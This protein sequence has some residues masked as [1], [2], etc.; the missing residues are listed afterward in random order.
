MGKTAAVLFG[1]CLY[2]SE[3]GRQVN[4]YDLLVAAIPGQSLRNMVADFTAGTGGKSTPHDEIGGR[5]SVLAS[6][7][8]LID[9]NITHHVWHVNPAYRSCMS[10]VGLA[11]IAMDIHTHETHVCQAYQFDTARKTL[12]LLDPTQFDY[13]LKLQQKYPTRP[14]VS[15]H[16][17]SPRVLRPA[18]VIA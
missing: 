6:D 14:I 9:L 8:T 2:D 15:K 11:G 13:A 5:Y 1:G 18:L 12:T 16:L 4:D 17:N 7:G 3:Q 10:G